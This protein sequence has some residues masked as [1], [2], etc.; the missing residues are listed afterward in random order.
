M[1][2]T[3]YFAEIIKTLKASKIAKID[4]TNLKNNLAKKFSIKVIPTDT[5]VLMNAAVSDIHK[6]GILQNKPTRTMSGVSVIAVMSKPYKCPHGACIMCPSNVSKGVP[7]SYTGKEPA[8]MR[9]IRN[10]FD[11]YLQVFNRLEQYVV[12]GHNFDKVELIIMGGTFPSFNYAYQKNFVMLALKAL[13]DFS[14]MFIKKK[15]TIDYVKFK[16]FFEL[17]GPVGDEER[18][19]SV[20]K[21]LLKLKGKSTL[22][23]E[24]LRNEKAFVKCIGMTVETRAD[25]GKLKH[26]NRLLELGVTRVE[27]G[28]Q[29]VYDSVLKTIHRGHT[30][31]DNI[32]SIRTLRDLGFKLNFHYMP[33]L[34]GV[35][36]K[37][38]FEGMLELFRNSDYVPD[39]LKIYPCMVMPETELYKLWKAGKFKPITTS[40]AAEMIAKFKAFV[41]EYCRIMRVQRDI[42]TYVTSAGVDKT[43]LRQYVS[44]F[45]LKNNITCRCIRCRQ[46]KEGVHYPKYDI[47]VREYDAAHGKEYFISAEAG[48]CLLG[49]CRLRLP[50]Q[51][52]RKEIT[53]DSALIRELHVYGEAVPVGE[54]GV[55]QH[56][57]IGSRL[58]KEAE[59]IAKSYGKN[60]IVVISGIG[61]R[62]YYIKKLGYKKDGVYV[63]KKI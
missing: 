47:H 12:T 63:S 24:Q 19:S 33:G 21:K 57:G 8:T 17:P 10:C 34:P 36:R 9:A 37:K 5:E 52:L 7:Q 59:G 6:L 58:M 38:D 32:E 60:K 61:V 40:E 18:T 13:N 48:D 23:A 46:P 62:G 31:T 54:V 11:P 49:F 1:S 45:M 27:L 35:N 56:N 16:K 53:S 4:M 28:I 55:V 2:Q 43:N 41:P 14:K 51:S 25:Y 15:G 26:D 3:Q 22:I 50:S 42:P 29:S 44:E 39:M 30:V 20:H